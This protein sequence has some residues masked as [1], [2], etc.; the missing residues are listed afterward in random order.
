MA[1]LSLT[2]TVNIDEVFD[3]IPDNP[4]IPE[5][6][7]DL[8]RAGI[9]D[10]T[11]R[12]YKHM[13]QKFTDAGYTIPCTE[14]ELSVYMGNLAYAGMKADSIRAALSAIKFFHNAY[15]YSL[16]LEHKAIVTMMR[17]IKDTFPNEP[18]RAPP[19]LPEHL[20]Q[21]VDFMR[22]EAEKW[23][24]AAHKQYAMERDVAMFL[25]TFYGGFRIGEV[26]ALKASDVDFLDYGVKINIRKSKT[27]KDRKEEFVAIPFANNTD[28]CAAT[29]LKRYF[30]K[31]FNIYMMQYGYL[32]WGRT[33]ILQARKTHAHPN[34]KPLSDRGY[35][36]R[37]ISNFKRAGLGQVGYSSHSFR[38]GMITEAL[39]K[40]HLPF[41]IM[42]QTRHKSVE[43]LNKYARVSDRFNES[44][45]TD[46][47]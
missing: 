6:V 5:E 38:A 28:Y 15:G 46:L 21:T 17:G 47:L 7:R 31:H 16:N 32:F 27:N 8:Y 30:D 41:S 35:R 23:V 12:A 10:N 43:T 45:V 36:A 22:S 39:K 14:E 42:A 20:K 34:E 44:P 19:L 1:N 18:D 33:G 26:L 29:E 11:K 2:K 25:L 24:R 40:G 9:N 4:T 37:I 3:A 13:I